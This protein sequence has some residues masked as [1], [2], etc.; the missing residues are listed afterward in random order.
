MKCISTCIASVLLAFG[1]SCAVF[2][3][4]LTND[5]T[6]ITATDAVTI[7]VMGNFHNTVR[8]NA[9]IVATTPGLHLSVSGDWMND[10]VSQVF[11]V[12]NSANSATVTFTGTNQSIGGTWPT[13]FLNVRIDGGGIK[14]LAQS[15]VVTDTMSMDSGIVELN[16]RS[17]AFVSTGTLKHER[18][19]S[20]VFESGLAGTGGRLTGTRP[21]QMG[22][23]VFVAGL[24]LGIASSQHL[25]A[26]YVSRGHVPQVGAGGYESIA[27]WY[28]VVPEYP[29]SGHVTA[30]LYY[31]DHELNGQD[32]NQLDAWHSG[33]MGNSWQ[34]QFGTNVPLFNYVKVDTCV[35][36]GW[37]TL[38]SPLSNPLPVQLVSFS[39]ACMPEA[40]GYV[41]EW[42]TASEVNND[43]FLL[44]KS[45]DLVTWI[46]VTQIDGTGNSNQTIAYSFVDSAASG[47]WYYRLS[48]VDFNGTI[49]VFDDD[50][51]FVS[52]PPDDVL[53]LFPNPNDGHF[54]VSFGEIAEQVL[55]FSVCDVLGK[56]IYDQPIAPFNQSGTA[57]FNLGLRPGTYFLTCIRK[58][59]TPLVIPFIVQ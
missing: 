54:T 9:R 7:T 51:V 26:T 13:Q 1:A 55:R 19:A 12:G 8:T 41:L 29:D 20:Y 43:Y 37:W 49:T 30:W 2:G 6:V 38:S 39:G 42:I 18:A 24:G 22:D 45:T 35:G 33:D 32:K 36:M 23:T 25:G 3:Q 57:Q 44:E 50:V 10:N 46:P 48:Q 28:E 17:I 56:V 53:S 40:R 52:C 5:G 31:F 11:A 4:G 59:N 14:T 16:G 27:R 21:V 47:S 58:G 15:I 34:Q